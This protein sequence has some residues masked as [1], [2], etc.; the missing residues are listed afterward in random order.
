VLGQNTLNKDLS[1]SFN[2]YNLLKFD[3]KVILDKAK[4]EQLIEFQAYGREFEFVLTPNDLRAANYRAVETTSSGEREMGRAEITT[5]K[6]KLL[7]DPDS[8]WSWWNSIANCYS[9][10]SS[11]AKSWSNGCSTVKTS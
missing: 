11:Y 3:K 8:P 10:Y 7:N 1:A 5:Y 9:R 6:G 4:S 2:R